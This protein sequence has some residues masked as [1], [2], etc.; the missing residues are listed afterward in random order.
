[1]L[2]IVAFL[3]QYH[4]V[5]SRVVGPVFIDMMDLN[6]TGFTTYLTYSWK[7]KDLKCC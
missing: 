2:E 6:T 7:L 5:L 1:M 3:A 4:N